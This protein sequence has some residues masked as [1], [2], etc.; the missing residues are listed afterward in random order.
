MGPRP[1]TEKEIAL[2]EGFA[3][4]AVVAI[5]NARLLDESR[6]YLDLEESLEYQTATGDALK[7]ISR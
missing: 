6:A 4:Q 7:V 5:E 2:L 1:F 3:A